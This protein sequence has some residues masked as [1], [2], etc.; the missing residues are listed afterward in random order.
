MER[1]RIFTQAKFN[2]GSDESIVFDSVTEF[3]PVKSKKLSQYT[4]SDKST[5]SN[6]SVKTNP[7][8]SITGRI[9]NSPIETYTGNIVGYEDLG[10]RADLAEKIL[11]KWYDQDIDL[12]IDT[13]TK[14]Y[15]QFQLIQVEP[16][17]DGTESKVFSLRFEKARRV[18]YQRVLLAQ[19]MTAEKQLDADNGKVSGKGD[20]TSTQRTAQV[21]LALQDAAKFADDTGMTQIKELTETVGKFYDAEFKVIEVDEEVLP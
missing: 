11:D 15:T 12:C 10:G 18:S 7:T 16:I 20:D 19:D 1:I 5:I 4:L 13:G 6:N 2:S 21:T 14:A 17:E 3:T 8:I 9:S